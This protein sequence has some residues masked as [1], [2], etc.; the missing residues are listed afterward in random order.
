M[1]PPPPQRAGASQ[2]LRA[3]PP[4]SGATVLSAF[5]CCL[6]TSPLAGRGASG[7]FE[8]PA[9]ST[10]A[11]SRSVQEQQTRLMPP[12]R[13]VP[14]GQSAGSRQARPEDGCLAPGFGTTSSFLR[15][16][17]GDAQPC[18]SGALVHL[19]G[20]HLTPQGRLS[21]VAHHDGLQ[22]TQH[23]AVWR[24]PRRAGAGGPSVLHLLHSTASESVSYITLLSAFVTHAPKSP[25]PN[26]PAAFDPHSSS[27]G[28][29]VIRRP[30]WWL[31]KGRIG[32]RLDL[33]RTF[34]RHRP[35][36]N[37]I[38]DAYASSRRIATL[39]G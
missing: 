8:R 5:G 1:A 31:C 24:L 34:G 14:P 37:Q 20:P 11:F 2:L 3:G 35:F 26:A 30:D 38:P 19:P 27:G 23:R 15:R 13:R 16:F 32:C 12:I 9:V 7:P 18:R 29:V 36:R 21:P 25:F 39:Y 17:N 4:A 22:P 28:G 33:L 10:L 6:G